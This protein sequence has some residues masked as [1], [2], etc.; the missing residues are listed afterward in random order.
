MIA[1]ALVWCH[2]GEAARHRGLN[3]TDLSNGPGCW[4]PG[5]GP[6]STCKPDLHSPVHKSREKA[7][8]AS[9]LFWIGQK[10]M[11]LGPGDMNVSCGAD[12]DC[13]GWRAMV[14]QWSSRIPVQWTTGKPGRGSIE[15]LEW[16]SWHTTWLSLLSS[17]REPQRDPW[18]SQV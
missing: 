6:S 12:V 7:G 2:W 8:W 16:N 18:G 5:W 1:A 11:R 9:G 4:L 14:H 15:A 10:R 17:C 3:R 13:T